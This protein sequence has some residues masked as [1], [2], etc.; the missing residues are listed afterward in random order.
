[1]IAATLV[2]AAFVYNAQD[3]G[4]TGAVA[5]S[6]S[7]SAAN[8]KLM[9]QDNY[10][11]MSADAQPLLHFWS[12]AVEEQFYSCCPPCYSSAYGWTAGYGC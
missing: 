3:A 5:A 11:E 7:V 12:L 2:A 9:L 10:F 4:S 6:A 8:M 1:V